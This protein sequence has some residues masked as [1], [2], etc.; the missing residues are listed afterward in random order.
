MNNRIL[1][2][3]AEDFIDDKLLH[4]L[5]ENTKEDKGRLREIFA[6]SKA[7]QALNLEEV[8]SLL[9]IKSR[10]GLEEL[11]ETAR[12][13]KRVIYGNRIVL[14]APLYI[15]NNC[16]N[17]CSYCGFRSSLT[18]AV[19]KTLTK[20]ELID[21]VTSLER[22]GHKRLILVYG[23]HPKYSPE[24][25]ADTVRTCYSV[26][27]DNGEIRRVNINAAPM[28]VEGYKIVKAAGIG[29]FQVFQET[30]HKE[31]YAKYHPANTVKGDYMWRLDAMD[32]A[33]EGGID[34]MGIGALFGL[35]DWRYDVLGLVSHAIHLQ[36]KLGVGPHT[37]SFPRIKPAFGLN[38]DL[39]YEVTDEQFKQLV[40]TLRI[41]VPYTGLIMTARESPKIRDEVIEFG[42]SQIDAGT[43][44][45][46]GGYQ[47]K[48]DR[49]QDLDREQFEVGDQREL[50][51][52][53]R[54]LIERGFIPSFCTSCYR[55]GRTGEH[56]M[57]YAIPGF[58]GNFCTPNA[59]LTLTEYLED[60]SSEETKK[61]G[62]EML[63]NEL[64]K[65]KNSER[66]AEIAGKIEQIKMGKRDLRY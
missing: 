18:N 62:Y 42:V 14:F 40:A 21:E 8:A 4:S 13:L 16:I 43:R 26:K 59:M 61:A 51:D 28:N 29:T 15:G 65:I 57:E 37:I 47:E 49:G 12:D 54:W 53:I 20:D 44:L 55:L 46:I 17:N 36:K 2:K 9:A 27:V 64:A 10:D 45:E 34:D 31:T 6:K 60:Y 66:R 5:I 19:R 38:I 23:E 48:R 11:Y 63:E 22:E 39:P 25:I 30:Y 41:S 56:F 3:D 50:D 52:A 7:K 35:Y 1:S 33:F 24:F 58:I 32:R